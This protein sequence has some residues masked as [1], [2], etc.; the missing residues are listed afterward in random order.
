VPQMDTLKKLAAAHD[1]GVD[2]YLKELAKR[3]RTSAR[4]S[5]AKGT[6]RQARVR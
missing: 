2:D 5:M 4:R 3:S 1:M 6:G